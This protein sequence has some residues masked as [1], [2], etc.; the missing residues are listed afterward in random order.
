MNEFPKLKFII[1]LGGGAYRLNFLALTLVKDGNRL[2]Y[3]WCHKPIFSACYLTFSFDILYIIKLALSL[4][5][6]MFS[7]SYPKNFYKNF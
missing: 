7:L 4:I 3:D 5:D 6:R 2:I 1:E